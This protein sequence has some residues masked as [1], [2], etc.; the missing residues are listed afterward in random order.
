MSRYDG[1]KIFDV[2][3]QGIPESFIHVFRTG[4]LDGPISK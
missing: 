4:I 1:V 2:R 3:I